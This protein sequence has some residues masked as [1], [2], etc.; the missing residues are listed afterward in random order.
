MS[1]P[2]NIETSILKSDQAVDKVFDYKP[3][4]FSLAIA[5]EAVDYVHGASGKTDFV[6]SELA[7]QQSGVAKLEDQRGQE[8]INDQVLL[9]LKEVQEK[10]YKE[11]Y[12]LGFQEGSERGFQQQKDDMAAKLKTLDA[13]IAS[14][15]SLKKDLLVENEGQFVEFAFEIAKRLALRDLSQNREAVAQ[16][17]GPLIQDMQN[18]QQVT[19]HAFSEDVPALE[20]MQKR[21][22]IP[23][24]I[25]KKVK[26]VAD[27][28]IQ[29]GDC[30]IDLQYGQVNITAAD[31][32]ERVWQALEKQ[33]LINKKS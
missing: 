9:K 5:S 16:V 23:L 15:E 27:P 22:D 24:E 7:A 31:R 3:R 4:E 10:A 33:I 20:E 14:I 17:I 26:L 18:E 6:M 8:M 11:A 19:I 2:K 1:M 28:S 30:V 12:D 32:V 25:L 13:L 29:P 21:T